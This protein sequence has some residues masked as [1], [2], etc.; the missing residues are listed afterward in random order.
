MRLCYGMGYRHYICTMALVI[1]RKMWNF[2]WAA[3]ND[4]SKSFRYILTY[5]FY[6]YEYYS[7]LFFVFTAYF[8]EQLVNGLTAYFWVPDFYDIWN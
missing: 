2:W 5:E 1:A 7:P 6:M 8:D 3:F 4:C